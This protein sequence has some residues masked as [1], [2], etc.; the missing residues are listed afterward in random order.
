MVQGTYRTLLC[1]WK[2]NGALLRH[3]ELDG[4]GLWHSYTECTCKVQLKAKLF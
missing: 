1:W 2:L 4:E 3:S